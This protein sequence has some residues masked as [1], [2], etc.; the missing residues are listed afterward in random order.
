MFISASC[1]DTQPK[2]RFLKFE[3]QEGGVA[4]NSKKEGVEEHFGLQFHSDST[5]SYSYLVSRVRCK[6]KYAGLARLWRST[7]SG[8]YYLN[9]DSVSIQG[10]FITSDSTQVLL[11]FHRK[12][13]GDCLGEKAPLMRYSG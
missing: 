5:V 11:K 3:L 9:S 13:R 1:S 8:S 12:E 10:F 7:D 4:Y 2:Q 6:Q